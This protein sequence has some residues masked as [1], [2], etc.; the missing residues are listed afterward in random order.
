MQVEKFEQCYNN[1]LELKHHSNFQND[2]IEIEVREGPNIAGPNG[3]ER[4]GFLERGSQPPPHQ[5]GVL[6][7]L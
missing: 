2:T 5:L 7:A 4:G 6:E 1:G 3:R